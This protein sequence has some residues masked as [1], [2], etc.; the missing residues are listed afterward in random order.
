VNEGESG[1]VGRFRYDVRTGTWWWSDEIFTLH[2]FAPGAVVPTTDLLLAHVHPDDVDKTRHLLDE[3]TTVGNGFSSYHRIVDAHRHIR[4]VLVAGH[5]ESDAEGHAVLVGH[6][7]DLTE[8]S[9]MDAKDEV[10]DAIA[11]VLEGR[12][13]IE[14]AKGV[15]M[16]ACGVTEDEAFRMLVTHSQTT[17][18]K[19]REV[20]QRLMSGLAEKPFAPTLPL[21]QQVV[22]LLD[23]PRLSQDTRLEAG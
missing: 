11:G 7:V 20:A 15:L 9:R 12:A 23:K 22:A 18:V 16:L 1:N 13:V 10:D 17:N 5:A 19:T 6:A 21:R 2:G 3:A 4:K 8:S 14:Q